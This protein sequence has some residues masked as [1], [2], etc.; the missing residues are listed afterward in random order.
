MTKSHTNDVATVSFRVPDDL[1]RRMD[2]HDVDWPDKLRSL[3]EEE[4]RREE[5][6]EVLARAR[7]FRKKHAKKMRGFS[8]SAEVIRSRREDH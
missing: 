4:V 7:A 1:R 8:M 2:A 5:M 3:L 6:R